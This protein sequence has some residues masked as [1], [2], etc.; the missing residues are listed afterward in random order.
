MAASGLRA[1][2][3]TLVSSGEHVM[4]QPIQYTPKPARIEPTAQEELQ[5][6]RETCHEHGLLRFAN[7]VIAANTQIAQTIANFAAAN[8]PY[9]I[10]VQG[11]GD[12]IVGIATRRA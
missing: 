8:V 1:A 10:C 6:L 12:C 7:D 11:R 3:H 2:A 5:R 9:C 4:A